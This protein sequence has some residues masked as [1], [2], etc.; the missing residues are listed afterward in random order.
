MTGHGYFCAEVFTESVDTGSGDLFVL[1]FRFQQTACLL[2]W[3]IEIHVDAT[4]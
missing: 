1:I 3:L 4:L 2:V